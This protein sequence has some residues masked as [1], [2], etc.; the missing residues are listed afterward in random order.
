MSKASEAKHK[1]EYQLKRS[2]MPE[3][4]KEFRFHPKRKWRF[5]YAWAPQKIAVEVH[6]ATYV[7]GRHTQGVGFRD[8]REK[9]N[10]AQLLG[11][12][13]L[14]VTIEQI[15]N[16]QAEVWLLKAMSRESKNGNAA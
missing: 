4:E 7:R 5:D 1:F 12:L 15:S 13:V 11:W 6:G 2:G 10:E 14:E 8:D 9:M 3:P 16:G